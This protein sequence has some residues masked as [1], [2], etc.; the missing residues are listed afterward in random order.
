MLSTDDLRV[1][2]QTVYG[3]SRGEDWNGMV[4]VAWVIKNRT[5]DRRWPDSP[6]KVAKQPFQFSAW[7][8]GDPNVREM[9]MA[10]FED[11]K[12]LSAYAA[13]VAVFCGKE[14]RDRTAG[15]NHY[16]GVYLDTFPNWASDPSKETGR[17]GQHVFYKL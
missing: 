14:E 7:N 11:E 3:E 16:H 2:A 17:I 4:A 1:V 10:S 13:A 8:V 9:L 6:S 15:A 5:A 12:Y